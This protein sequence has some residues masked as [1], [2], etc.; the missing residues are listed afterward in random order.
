MPTKKFIYAVVENDL[1]SLA[2]ITG[3]A[4]AP[5]EM[6]CYNNLAAVVSDIDAVR[7]D[8]ELS[9]QGTSNQLNAD[10]L[11][12]QQVNFQ[13]LS[14]SGGMLPLKFGFT[15]G[16]RSEV[17]AVLEH[18]YL[19]LR[20]GLDR[21]RNQVEL[22]VQV[23]WD[24][25]K[26][27]SEIAYDHAEFISADPVKTGKFLFEA[28]QA[29]KIELID[30]I[31]KQLSPLA[32]DFSDGPRKAED[33]ILNRSYLVDRRSETQ[34]D[35]AMNTLG[36]CYD[37]ILSFRYIGPLPAYSFV[38]IELNQGNFILLDK[39][40]KILK[41]QQTTTWGGIKSAYRQQLMAYHPDFHPDD[42]QA[43][44]RCKEVIAAFDMVSAYC[45][46]FPDFSGNDSSYD[47]SRNEVEKHFIVDTKSAVLSRGAASRSVVP[48]GI[49]L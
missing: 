39:A 11:A 35:A 2:G 30:L 10:L 17:E 26:I 23:T 46:S 32:G 6:V 40:R 41:L 36:N 28:A 16:N 29:K 31:N 5:L 20:S 18:A 34:F 44:E 24:M 47:F 25:N 33:M 21:L 7:F 15:A 4:A 43:A 37:G 49:S 13:L 19:Q 22:V 12:Y 45:R 48:D 1:L 38:N 3:L 42:A 8:T 27:I 9:E 14:G